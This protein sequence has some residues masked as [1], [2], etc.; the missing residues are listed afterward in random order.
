MLDFYLVLERLFKY[1]SLATLNNVLREFHMIHKLLNI[2]LQNHSKLCILK[3]LA[4]VPALRAG[5]SQQ[6]ISS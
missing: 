2:L 3:T 1:T 6:I 5:L 4:L